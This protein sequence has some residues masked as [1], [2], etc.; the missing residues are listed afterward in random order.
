MLQEKE[1][2]GSEILIIR[3]ISKI[4]QD[5]KIRMQLR[6]SF[7]SAVLIWG[8]LIGFPCI[9][10][11][12]DS[13]KAQKLLNGANERI[14]RLRKAD[15]TLIALDEKGN[16][17]KNVTVKVEQVNHAFLFG[18]AALSLLKHSDA[19]KEA[20]YQKQFGDLFNFATILSF[21]H[22][23]DPEPDRLN[24]DTL[25]AQAR[26]LQEMGIRVK[27]HPLILA[28]ACPKWV[29]KD[30][31]VTRELTQKRID[32]L[33]R[34]TK[35]LID[36]W[37]VVGDATTA[38]G[39]QNGLG[40]WARKAGAVSFTSDA[41]KWARRAN[42]NALLIYNDYK[43]DADYLN[44]IRDVVKQKAPLDALGLEAHMGGSEWTLEKVCETAE[45]FQKLGKPLHF[46]EI[47]VL[48]DNRPGEPEK[49]ATGELRQADYVEKFYTLLFSHPA[50][51]GIMWWN[52]VDGDW[53]N[54]PGGLLRADLTP[55]PAYE[56][57]HKLIRE[58]WWTAAK[59][60]TNSKGTVN[61][62]GFAGRYRFTLQTTRGPLTTEAEIQK[63]KQNAIRLKI[64][65]IKGMTIKRKTQ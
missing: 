57:L 11:S 44:L 52:F 38:S 48:S 64:P 24:L 32:D 15:A 30:P 51:E 62:R 16:P 46:S 53:D 60:T 17:L 54:S 65:H 41:L 21:W 29:P 39:V 2:R 33:V 9:A 36:V 8:L 55:K 22:E 49:A 56:R 28:G 26:R 1:A 58:K 20:I 12:Q 50:V 27:A 10:S 18:C 23:T 45:T 42:P 63:G 25:T 14:E 6:K 19:Q 40:A 61:F 4:K 7:P 35:G 5:T 43:L 13:A 34:R 47:T 3:F 59:L 37:D 31:D